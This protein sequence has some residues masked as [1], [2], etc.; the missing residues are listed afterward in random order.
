MYMCC[1]YILIQGAVGTNITIKVLCSVMLDSSLGEP[2]DRYAAVAR[3]MQSTFSQPLHKHPVQ[4]LHQDMSNTSWS[5]PEAGG[6]VCVCVCSCML[7]CV[8]CVCLHVYVMFLTCFPA[9]CFI[10]QEVWS[11]ICPVLCL[12]V[13]LLSFC[14]VH[15][16]MRT[17]ILWFQHEMS[18]KLD[19]AWR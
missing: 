4:E 5:G 12:C 6:G 1:I 3:L 7:I 2:Y 11:L 17:N 9:C 10:L 19:L 18:K 16:W 15:P 14:N 8:C 13:F